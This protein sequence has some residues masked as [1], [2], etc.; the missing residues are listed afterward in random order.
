MQRKRDDR[1]GDLVK[2]VLWTSLL[3]YNLAWC[4]QLG[5]FGFFTRQPVW[6]GDLLLSLVLIVWAG[7][8]SFVE[9][10]TLLRYRTV[11]WLFRQL[12]YLFWRGSI[13]VVMW[14]VRGLMHVVGWLMSKAYPGRGM[15]LSLDFED[16]RDF[17]EMLRT[18]K[19]E[20][21]PYTTSGTIT[22]EEYDE[23]LQYRA[24]RDADIL[25]TALNYPP[26]APL[27]VVEAHPPCP[28]RD[29]TD[30]WA[31]EFLS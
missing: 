7:W 30:G 5:Y 17:D 12:G 21:L 28:K 15:V 22:P 29:D 19:D 13:A 3:L 20:G 31:D 9:W 18:A 2:T 1:I 14:V 8:F 16:R 23:P 11:P 6:I 4:V 27:R 26:L 24:P 25:D 10:R